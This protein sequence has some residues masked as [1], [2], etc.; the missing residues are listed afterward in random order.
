M[1]TYNLWR[2]SDRGGFME[3]D[4]LETIHELWRMIVEEL[5]ARLD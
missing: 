1:G 5:I 2:M 4:L 3:D